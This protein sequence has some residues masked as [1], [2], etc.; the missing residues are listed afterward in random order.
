MSFAVIT[1]PGSIWTARRAA[2]ARFHVFHGT[3]DWNTPVEP[4]RALEAW[5]ATEG[6]LDL[7]FTFYEGGHAGTAA[8]QGEMAELLRSLVS[9]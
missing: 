8:A 9:R 1:G 2:P 7:R 3:K 5:N 6:H 4:V